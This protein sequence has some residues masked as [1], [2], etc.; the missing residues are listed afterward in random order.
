MDIHT[1]LATMDPCELKANGWSVEAL[2]TLYKDFP[3][4]LLYEKS[5]NLS[6]VLLFQKLDD[7]LWEILFLATAP[8]FRRQGHLL[9][10]F[11]AFVR[12]NPGRIWLECRSDNQAALAL[13][14]KCGFRESGKRIHYYS[15][16]RD[17]ILMEFSG[18]TPR[19]RQS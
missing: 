16:G 9:E 8:Q 15:D 2:L 17:A 19:P 11:A 1:W 4:K 18:K 6:S 5:G 12:S 3:H 7:E 10:L 13:Y 14:A